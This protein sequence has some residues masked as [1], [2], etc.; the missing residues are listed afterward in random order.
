M[1]IPFRKSK[2]ITIYLA[3]FLLLMAA[4]FLIFM[5][6]SSPHPVLGSPLFFGVIAGLFVIGAI[7]LFFTAWKRTKSKLPA[8]QINK[9]GFEDF[10]S[11]INKGFI[12][13]D[14]VSGLEIKEVVSSKFIV[15]YLKDP[16]AYLQAQKASW[17]KEQLVDR[18]KNYGSP[19][20]V[21]TNAMQTNTKAL[22][23]I[24]EKYKSEYDK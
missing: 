22:F 13:W 7:K 23:E 14:K 1:D 11:K 6:P 20:C 24:L 5:P 2:N 17:R 8:M 9:K 12:P 18:Y 10:T 21:A 19:F 16:E 4:L 15:V 3:G